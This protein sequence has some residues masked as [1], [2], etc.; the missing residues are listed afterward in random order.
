VIILDSSRTTQLKKWLCDYFSID[1][2]KLQPLTGDA[3]FR[4]YYR[5]NINDQSYIAVDAIPSMSNNLA[6]V[7]IQQVLKEQQI[8]VPNI[9][10]SDLTYG[11]MCLSDLGDELFSDALTLDNISDFYKKAINVLPLIA[12]APLPKNYQL[13]LYDAAFLNVECHIFTQW[14]LGVHLN[15]VLTEHEKH[16][17]QACFDLL[18]NSALEQPQVVVH[19]DYHSRNLMLVNHDGLHASTENSQSDLLNTATLSKVDLGVI[20]FQDAVIGPITYDIVSL[21]KDCYV[22]WPVENVQHLFQYFCQLMA[23]K[24]KYPKVTPEQW[25]R[26]FD[27][28]GLQRHI[29]A[30][31]IFARLNHRDNKSSYLKDIPLT[32]SYIVDISAQYSELAFLYDLVM[33]KIIPTLNSKNKLDKGNVS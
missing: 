8:T 27:F 16:Q 29:K 21:L 1:L 15:I 5:F 4:K 25:L 11:F 9:I 3:G 14:L 22:K 10:S 13:P 12:A 28:M 23:V 24:A 19:R 20:D 30:S 31:G 17:L 18:I 6:F 32:L 2:I 33:Q 7:E 26:W